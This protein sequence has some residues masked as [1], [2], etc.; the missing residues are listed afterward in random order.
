MSAAA[1]QVTRHRAAR[2]VVMQIV[3]RVLNL[4]LGVVVTALVTRTLGAVYYG[5]LTTLVVVFGM[6]GYLTDF[7][8]EAAV[9]REASREPDREQQW[10]GALVLQRLI[11]LVPIMLASLVAVLVLQH[12][13]QMLISGLILVAALPFGTA[14]GVLGIIFQLRVNNLVP[15]LVLTLKSILLAVA[16]GLIF[17]RGGGLIA[18]TIALSLTNVIGAVVTMIAALRITGGWPPLPRELLRPLVRVAIPLGVGSVLIVLYAQIDQLMVFEIAGSH[19]AGLY[20]A[21]YNVLNQAHFIPISLLTTLTPIIAAS[22]P[23]QRERMLKAVRL[24]AEFLLVSSLGAL[25]FTII[26]ATPLVQ[27]FFG[28][29]FTAAAPALPVLAG[30]FVFIC[31]GYLNGTLLL[32]LGIQRHFLPIGVAGLVFNV[33][34]NLILVPAYGFMGAAWMTLLTEVLV[35]LS[36]LVLILRTLGM[37]RVRIGRMG[38]TVAAA[39]LLGGALSALKLINGSLLVLTI[40][41]CLCYPA[42]LFALRALAL[43]DVRILLKRRALA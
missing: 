21:V 6:V 10:L 33:V 18:W 13:H 1:S 9:T 34:G 8:V 15:M 11:V 2:D 35:F 31:F 42:L 23:G 25:A 7:G 26:A 19:S 20:G 29:S 14:V 36:S 32:V 4:A 3:A 30:A 43:D 28:S 24:S 37:R 12:G 39:V 16:I 38:R 5:Q 41:A 17:W 40:A 22:W 27:L